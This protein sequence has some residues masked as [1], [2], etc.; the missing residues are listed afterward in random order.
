MA[1]RQSKAIELCT[2]T[3]NNNNNNNNNNNK[4]LDTVCNIPSLQ[5]HSKPPNPVAFILFLPIFVKGPW[6][7]D[8][9]VVL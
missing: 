5:Y 8:A 2:A 6:A 3:K 1:S 7:L 9:G 4:K